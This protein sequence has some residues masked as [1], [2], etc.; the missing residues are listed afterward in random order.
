MVVD[1]NVLIND[2]KL[3]KLMCE[4]HE[5]KGEI[6]FVPKVVSMTIWVYFIQVYIFALVA[7][8]YYTCIYHMSKEKF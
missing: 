3:I 7:L 6:G 8:R 5:I 2:L 1:T 4:L